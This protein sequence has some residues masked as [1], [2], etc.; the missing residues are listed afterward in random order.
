[1]FFESFKSILFSDTLLADIFITEYMP[2]MDPAYLKVYIHCL[3]LCKH[4][5]QVTTK[6]LSKKLDLEVDKVKN[7]LIYLESIGLIYRKESNNS[8]VMTDLKEKELN[9]MYR[10][11]NTSTPDEAIFSSARNK[12]RNEIVTAINNTFFQGLMAPS[13]YTDI[14]SWFDKYLFEEDVMFMLFRHCYDLNKFSKNYIMTVAESWNRKNIHNEIDLGNYMTEYDSFKDIRGKIVKKLKLT[15][16][17]TEY[18]DKF[19]EKWFITYKYDFEIVEMALKKT[20]SKTNPNFNYID[21]II[22]DWHKNELKTKEDILEYEKIRK[23]NA[24]KTTSTQSAIP[25]SGN[26]EQ[27]KYDNE[28]LNSLY[29][30]VGSKK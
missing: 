4:N 25:Q 27:R 7:A 23:S 20:T 21:A 16:N 17:L 29:K 28:Y 15:R 18:E 22:S 8:I 6:E 5:K 1:M 26:F 11:K 13:W 2:T 9:K 12:K 14:D 30:N 24:S 3:F 19:V 10:L